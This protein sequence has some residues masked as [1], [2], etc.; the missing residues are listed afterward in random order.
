MD[1]QTED[2]RS[3][4]DNKQLAFTRMAE[5]PE[6]KKWHHLEVLRKS[7]QIDEIDRIVKK[8]LQNI[9]VEIKEDGKWKRI[10]KNDPLPDII[11]E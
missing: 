5:T 1:T 10:G 9:T 8:E 2:S 3:Q 6:F 7:G 4:L 11:D